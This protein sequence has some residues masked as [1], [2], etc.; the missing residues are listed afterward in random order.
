MGEAGHDGVQ[1][2]L[3]ET[4]TRRVIHKAKL[5]RGASVDGPSRHS[6]SVSFFQAWGGG[7]ICHS[8]PA[9]YIRGG[10]SFVSVIFQPRKIAGRELG[11]YVMQLVSSPPLETLLLAV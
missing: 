6:R 8:I 7:R 2:V 3:I 10:F 1:S 5:L 4:Q 9:A 11:G